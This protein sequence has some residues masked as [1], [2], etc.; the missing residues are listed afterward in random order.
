MDI[1]G[2]DIRAL[3]KV[4]GLTLAEAA[5]RLG[6]SIGWLSQVETGKSR[7][8]PADLLDMA[9]ALDA[10]VSLL[11]PSGVA[12]ERGT[13]TRAGHGRPLGER[14]PGLD[15]RLLSPDLTDGFEL[16]HS[17]FAPGSRRDDPVD[18]PTT[19]VVHML[20]GSLRIWLAEVEHTLRPGDTARLRDAPFRWANPF[21]E[22][23][24]ALW[25]ITPAIYTQDAR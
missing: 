20:S 22:P 13:V 24:V 16:I 8:A 11:A 7:L 12:A 21:P 18:R 2:A 15:E 25:F 1:D 3:R 6:K 5:T 19:E 17:V 14:V 23:A 9:E 10:P 4:R